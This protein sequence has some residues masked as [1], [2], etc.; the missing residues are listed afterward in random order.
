MVSVVMPCY[1]AARYVDEAIGSLQKQTYADLEI[2]AVNDGSTDDTQAHLDR[3]A[4]ND[5]R[6]RVFTQAN[7]GPS[8]ARNRAMRNLRGQYVCFLDGDDIYLPEKIERQVRFLDEHP[9]VDLVFSDYYHGDSELNLIALTSGRI[10]HT[11]MVEA[12]AMRNWFGIHAVLFRRSLMARVGE[13]DESLRMAEDW[14]YWIRC[15]QTGS[16]AYVAGPM[17]IYRVHGV[18]AHFN[19]DSMFRGGKRVL[20]KHFKSDPALYERALASWYARSAKAQWMAGQRVKTGVCL[21]L[22]AVHNKM[23]G[24]LERLGQ[25]RAVIHG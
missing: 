14:D 21:A 16:F 22:S 10:P 23:A 4:A 9:A 18:Q 3:L 1:N 24:A 12:F 13:F 7:A 17:T 25:S 19:L 2:L 11:D 20:Q 6:V 5:P 15:A 8:A